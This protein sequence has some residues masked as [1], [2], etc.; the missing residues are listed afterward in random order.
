MLNQSNNY[1]NY[2]LSYLDQGGNNIWWSANN[3]IS[4]QATAELIINGSGLGAE[5]IDV[6]CNPICSE[7]IESEQQSIEILQK[8][9]NLI[10]PT[11]SKNPHQL[12]ITLNNL[13]LIQQPNYIEEG[14]IGESCVE[15]YGIWT[16]AIVTN[17][18]VLIEEDTYYFVKANP[19]RYGY[20]YIYNVSLIHEET[21]E[22]IIIIKNKGL[23]DSI[24]I[25]NQG[26]PEGFNPCITV[27]KF[28]IEQVITTYKFVSNPL[29]FRSD[30]NTNLPWQ[31]LNNNTEE[32]LL[33]I[34][35]LLYTSLEIE[36]KNELVLYKQEQELLINVI[37]NTIN[38]ISTSN[39]NP[40]SYI[41]NVTAPYE[42]NSLV[43]HEL[44]EL[45]EIIINPAVYST[46]TYEELSSNNITI[47]LMLLCLAKINKDS[48]RPKLLEYIELCI[49]LKTSTLKEDVLKLI[50]LV[51]TYKITKDVYH[52]S[53]ATTLVENIDKL[54]K[55]KDDVYIESLDNPTITTTSKVFGD[56]LSNYIN[57][58]PINIKEY[59]L[60]DITY[61]TDTTEVLYLT[62]QPTLI[63]Y[64]SINLLV[65]KLINCNLKHN[66][67][68]NNKLI[69][70]VLN[71]ETTKQLNT[72]ILNSLSL[73]KQEVFTK[74]K[75]YIPIDF[76]WLSDTTPTQD[77]I[78]RSVIKPII[79]LYLH[80]KYIQ[81]TYIEK[82]ALTNIYKDSLIA[83]TKEL[84]EKTI[85]FGKRVT[86]SLWPGRYSNSIDLEI[87]GFYDTEILSYI[88]NQVKSLGIETNLVSSLEMP[89]VSNFN[90]CFD[91]SKLEDYR[92]QVDINGQLI[93][94]SDGQCDLAP[95]EESILLQED[96]FPVTQETSINDYFI[97]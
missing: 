58:K 20:S 65:L 35:Y 3:V 64:D 60:E 71:L 46:T 10:Y 73:F 72:D 13:D 4:S 39:S 66:L 54:Y 97:L 23:L 22:E 21:G 62:N 48:L 89:I 1:F 40:Y 82:Q 5:C 34:V 7:I 55:I 84:L 44:D 51:E 15:E 94:L 52:L 12:L 85:T 80:S 86:N 78:I 95:P 67:S 26:V 18:S 19:D 37:V 30:W 28:D 42:F 33:S 6:D 27:T 74:F 11:F 45:E 14:C 49:N 32:V 81:D 83:N 31:P 16:K 87:K 68:I 29:F 75:S 24:I 70:D 43:T 63:T 17:K 38:N 2:V 90:L 53:I 50:A 91:I 56:L 69:I 9:Q 88:N 77:L 47:I 57:N 76:G 41:K 79:D 93:L 61:I 92:C 36:N 25:W 8:E 96:T 59:V